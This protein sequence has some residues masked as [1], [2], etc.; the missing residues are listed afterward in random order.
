MMVE[1]K[2]ESKW[3]V[4]KV[5]SGQEKKIKDHLEIELKRSGMD[6]VI[7]QVFVPTEKVYQ[8]RNG[9]KVVKEKTLF[10]GYMY[11]EVTHPGLNADIISE[12]RSF[13]SIMNFLGGK[14]HKPEPLR[15]SEVQKLLGKVD[16]ITDGGE[17]ISEPF[18][19]NETVKIIDGPFNDFTGTIEEIYEEKKKL[20]VIVKIF[21]RRTP[22]EVNFLQV[23]KIS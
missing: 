13:P 7:T 5:F 2:R 11:I 6:R 18:I 16:E 3:Y 10:P 8:I 20:K 4:L 1:T 23:D 15:A 21:G 17:I 22:V 14:D 9:K 12:I 19:I